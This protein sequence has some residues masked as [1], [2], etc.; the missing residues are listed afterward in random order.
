VRFAKNEVH[1]WSFPDANQLPIFPIYK[2]KD[3][4]PTRRDKKPNMA[5]RV[6]GTALI[7]RKKDPRSASS[8]RGLSLIRASKA[9]TKAEK[10]G[11]T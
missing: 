6:S 1:V 11:T 2:T 8:P 10:T 4:E 9:Q 7:S 5:Q 3:E